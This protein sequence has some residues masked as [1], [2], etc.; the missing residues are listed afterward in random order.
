MFSLFLTSIRSVQENI[1]SVPLFLFL[2]EIFWILLPYRGP[3]RQP[4]STLLLPSDQ[5]KYHYSS[6]TLN[7]CHNAEQE[8]RGTFKWKTNI[9]EQT[10][11]AFFKTAHARDIWHWSWNFKKKDISKWLFQKL[12]N[13]YSLYAGEAQ[14]RCL[15]SDRLQFRTWDFFKYSTANI[16][17]SILRD[18]QRKPSSRFCSGASRGVN[19]HDKY[20]NL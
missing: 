8:R 14:H 1:I 3:R 12:H 2:V 10:R 6:L 13:T 4:C 19:A 5:F 16:W 11:T 17:Q 15:T 7:F 20:S 18:F 9:S